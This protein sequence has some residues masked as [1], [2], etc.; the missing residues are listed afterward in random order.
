MSD[1][2]RAFVAFVHAF[3]GRLLPQFSP[4][5]KLP[6]PPAPF[7]IAV[8][9]PIFDGEFFAAT[10]LAAAERK[11]ALEALTGGSRTKSGWKPA[12]FLLAAEWQRNVN[13]M[14]KWT[15][16]REQAKTH[17]A[18]ISGVLPFRRLLMRQGQAAEVLPHREENS[19]LSA[20]GAATI[21]R[22]KPA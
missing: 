19:F 17:A 16:R 4:L 21:A 3:F 2:L 14:S 5:S 9:L 12:E 8:R 22:R 20:V 13:L 7:G 15:A 10:W 6:A 11:A 18:R 1:I